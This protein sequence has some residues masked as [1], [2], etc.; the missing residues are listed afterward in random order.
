[1]NLV[2]KAEGL[3]KRFGPLEALRGVSFEIRAGESVCV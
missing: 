2:L 1:M 3:V